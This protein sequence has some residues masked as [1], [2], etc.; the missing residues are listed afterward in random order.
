MLDVDLEKY[1]SYMFRLIA[2]LGQLGYMYLRSFEPFVRTYN[3]PND[4]HRHRPAVDKNR[5]IHA[6]CTEK[7]LAAKRIRWDIAN[8]YLRSEP[9]KLGSIKI[10]TMRATN[11]QAA[12]P[13]YML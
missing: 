6:R 11:P 7:L 9:V 8:T 2:G 1:V 3:P 12:L 13:I 10:G 4:D 5:P